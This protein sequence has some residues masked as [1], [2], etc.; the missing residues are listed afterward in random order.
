MKYSGEIFTKLMFK[1]HVAFTLFIKTFGICSS[2]R[3][4]HYP[5]NGSALSLIAFVCTSVSFAG[6]AHRHGLGSSFAEDGLS[7][8]EGN[9][10]IS[11]RLF[12]F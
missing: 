3:V 12:V 6:V 4:Q 2:G 7:H 5:P 10:L 8:R 1:L 11:L 9:G